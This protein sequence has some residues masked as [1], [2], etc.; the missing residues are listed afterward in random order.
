MLTPFRISPF[1][2]ILTSSECCTGIVKKPISQLIRWT[3]LGQR[4]VHLV[5]VAQLV[6]VEL[7]DG[8]RAQFGISTCVS[9]WILAL[10][11]CRIRSDLE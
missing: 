4:N 8:V 2:K 7:W 3:H 10:L 9:R 1:L 11:M 6:E 5:D